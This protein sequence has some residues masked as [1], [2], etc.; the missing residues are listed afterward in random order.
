MFICAVE[1]FSIIKYFSY[2]ECLSYFTGAGPLAMKS[3][4]EIFV[5][6]DIKFQ[7]IV[8]FL[9]FHWCFVFVCYDV[10][11]RACYRPKCVG[12]TAE[13][14]LQ[15]RWCWSLHPIKIKP[16]FF[17]DIYFLKFCFKWK[18]GGIKRWKTHPDY[19]GLVTSLE[20]K[21]SLKHKKYTSWLRSLRRF[22]FF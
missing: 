11:Q 7:F 10:L 22:F 16:I 14:L 5:F 20:H 9:L 6:S 15:I 21:Y 1:I 4:A 2:Y 19:G 8:I 13:L 12:Q 3:R 18:H 17:T